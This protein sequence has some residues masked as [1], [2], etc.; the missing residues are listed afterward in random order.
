MKCLMFPLSRVDR[1]KKKKEDDM[2]NLIHCRL[3][4]QRRHPR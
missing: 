3:N 1:K 4:E 2:I